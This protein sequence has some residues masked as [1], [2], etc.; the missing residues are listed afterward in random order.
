LDDEPWEA[1]KRMCEA[2]EKG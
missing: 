2:Y 1:L